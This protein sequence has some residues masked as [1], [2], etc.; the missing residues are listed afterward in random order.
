[1][2]TRKKKKHNLKVESPILFGG[3]S[4]DFK[5][6]RQDSHIPLRDVCK[7]ARWGARVF[8]SFCNKDQVVGT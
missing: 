5:P 1:M 4:E 8:K 3:H 2:T 7:E 6:G